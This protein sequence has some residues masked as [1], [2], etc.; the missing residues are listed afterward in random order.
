MLKR[1]AI[2]LPML[3]APAA[4]AEEGPQ[5]YVMVSATGEAER[6]PDT[7]VLSLAVVTEGETA[8]QAFQRNNEQASRLVEGLKALGVEARHI[9]T[10]NISI[11]PRYDHSGS[12][13]GQQ[14]RIV[15][16]TAENEVE[17]R[18]TSLEGLGAR[19]DAAVELGAN[20]VSGPQFII[21]EPQEA[22]A[23]ARR[24]AF[25]AAYAKAQTYADAGNFQLGPVLRVEEGQGYTPYPR[26]MMMRAEMAPASAPVEAG[27]A[28]ISVSVTLKIAME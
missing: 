13:R 16:Y 26:P 7:A 17:V 8:G 27:T 5:R 25:E 24:K 9:A 23:E 3:L 14:P 12:E 20:R 6:V 22:E 19:L 2:C 10:R 4:H 28:T 1:L 18:F 11:Q 15:G 21:S